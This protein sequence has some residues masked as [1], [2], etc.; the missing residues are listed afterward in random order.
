MAENIELDFIMLCETELGLYEQY[1]TMSNSPRTGR[2]T[3]YFKKQW[4]LNRIKENVYG[5]MRK[6]IINNSYNTAKQN[7]VKIYNSF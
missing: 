3:L 1:V 2:V 7:S 4:K 5:A 6:H